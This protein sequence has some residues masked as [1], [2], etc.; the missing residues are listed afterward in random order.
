M[1]RPIAPNARRFSPVR[2]MGSRLRPGSLM[3]SYA[4]IHGPHDGARN[5]RSFRP[6]PRIARPPKAKERHYARA[7]GARAAPT[8]DRPEPELLLSARAAHH[9]PFRP[10]PRDQRDAEARRPAA[11]R[12][13][14][15]QRRDFRQRPPRRNRPSAWAR[16]DGSRNASKYTYQCQVRT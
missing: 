13:L 2:C 10:S 8:A 12:A 1:T 9:T 5:P 6:R 3:A 14:I 11:G 16:L 7:S 15:D 4:G